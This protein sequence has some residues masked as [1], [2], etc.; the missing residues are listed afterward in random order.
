MV[1]L[2][3]K[4]IIYFKTTVNW[5]DDEG[6]IFKT[7]LLQLCYIVAYHILILCKSIRI[8]NLSGHTLQK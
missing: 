5:T 3:F 6:Q 7:L 1:Y 4:I 8:S 2:T